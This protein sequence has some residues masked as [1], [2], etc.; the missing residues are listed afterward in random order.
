[1]RPEDSYEAQR[2]LYERELKTMVDKRHRLVKLSERIDWKRFEEKF[3]A[4]YCPDF[5]PPSEWILDTA[6]TE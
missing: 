2:R 4:T 6:G 3:G 1:M 5:P